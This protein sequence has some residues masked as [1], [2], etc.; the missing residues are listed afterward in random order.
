[1][2]DIDHIRR[3]L[4]AS[5]GREFWRSLDEVAATPEFLDLLHNEF[6]RQAA[7]LPGGGVERREFLKLMAASLALAGL[8]SCTRQPEEKI[9][10]YV[11]APE[12]AVVG[13]PRHFAT[14]IVR[15][16]YATGVVVETHDGR[17]TKIEGNPWHPASLG[18]TDAVTQAALLE[19]YDPDRAQVVTRAGVI[20][21]WG[22]FRGALDEALAVQRARKGAGLRIL[23]GTVTS[24][25]LADRIESLLQQFPQARWHAYEGA[26]RDGV[27][28][29]SRIIYG[30]YVDTRYG[31]DQANV[32]VCLDA[33][34]F[35]TGP[36][37]VRYT[38]D[39]MS[40]RRP[41]QG[42][43]P[44]SRLYVLES[45]PSITGSVADH[46][47]P[48]RSGDV[49]RVVLA[50]ASK[51]GIRFDQ[52]LPALPPDLAETVEII[53]Q[54]LAAN[55]GHCVVIAGDHQPGIVHA[56]VHALNHGL[57]SVGSTEYHTETVEVR[58]TEHLTSLRELVTDMETGAVE[59]LLILGG[60]P[61][62]TAPVDLRFAEHLARVPLCV[63]LSLYEDETSRQCHWHVPQA[64]DL[65]A[66]SDARAFDGAT[67][68]LQPLVM[69]LYGGKTAHEV[70]DACLGGP[71]RSSHDIV[72][73]YWE[74]AHAAAP[75]EGDFETFW[76]RVLHDGVVPDSMARAKYAR[77][78]RPWR[79]TTAA[80]ASTSTLEIVFRVDGN[81][82]DGRFANNGWLQ[83]LPRPITKLTWDNAVL[84]APATAERLGLANEDVVELRLG[85]RSVHGPVWIVPGH[86][87][88][89]VTVHLGYGRTRAGR[90]GTGIGFDAYALRTSAQP[91][92]ATGLEIRPTGAR[93]P[94]A[95]TQQ[96]HSMEGRHLV[97]SAPLFEY[98]A[99][100]DFAAHVTH[101]PSP[102]LSLFPGHPYEG[103]AWGMVIDLGRC[104]G[105]NA[106][107]VACQ[108]ENNIPVVGKTE[109]RRGREMHWI[110]VDTYYE[111][112]LDDP[113]LHHQPVP[114]M[115]CENAPCEVVC[116]VNATVHS[117]E[118]LNEMVYNRCVG[119]RYCSNNCPYKVR[120]FNF[121][122]Y[123]NWHDETV[124]M[125]MNPDVTVRSR[126]VMEKCTYCVQRIER[127]R[128][129]AGREGRPIGDG[130]VVT[131]CQQ[132]CPAEAIVFG[133]LNQ[134]GGRAARLRADPR[135]YGLLSD[136]NTRPRTTYL[137]AVTNPNPALLYAIAARKAREGG[138]TD[139]TDDG[140]GH[141]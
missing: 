52:P 116:P 99:H 82:D 14:A 135:N 24:P 36:G 46:R 136:R 65:E 104:T 66:W 62:Y 79:S 7:A 70:L 17:P 108:A 128:I 105:C 8:G 22:S 64:H 72:R 58:P 100:P 16:G 113:V 67:T 101:E 5:T 56:M 3:K 35:A 122:L 91:G 110:R 132:A 96:H 115:H 48:L 92:I 57:G 20:D 44:M 123:T 54:D 138:S 68:I 137:A 6:P 41:E 1:V 31:L 23:T 94:L 37:H 71:E 60:N 39:F 140:G 63:H 125:A 114:C 97:R 74:T 81:V 134:T 130:Q 53:A 98:Q 26:N 139:G 120:R 89:S 33:D 9:V 109:V 18:A 11:R 117:S 126:G 15:G 34:I 73:A 103:H 86:A 28:A 42:A 102:D 133:D 43:P 51:V 124:K 75:R 83:E 85:E 131:A 25:T 84:I 29:G 141:S 47:I 59:L 40:R 119:T 55:R 129:T 93:H 76:R 13:E 69:P 112:A 78:L 121:F 50:L 32:V 38:R 61:V 127:V 30:E 10:P 80:P 2:T 107:T 118:G 87:P 19:L 45:T 88:E 12:H 21:T 111:G 4:A 49:H 95:T 106:C 27:R 90:V 77:E